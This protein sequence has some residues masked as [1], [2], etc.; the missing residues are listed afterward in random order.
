MNGYRKTMGLSILAFISWGLMVVMM[1]SCA[2]Q[3]YTPVISINLPSGYGG[4]T[5]CDTKGNPVIVMNTRYLTHPMVESIRIHE[6]EHVRQMKAHKAGCADFL[7]QYNED[8]VFRLESEAG[9]M[10]A[11]LQ[12]AKDKKGAFTFG[13]A[14]E[15]MVAI[16]SKAYPDIDVRLHIP[17]RDTS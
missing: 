6:N 5:T 17:C 9:A 13:G 4:L 7:K 16:L 2:P 12:A 8:E 1:V 3:M 11:E 14:F 10:C 15:Q